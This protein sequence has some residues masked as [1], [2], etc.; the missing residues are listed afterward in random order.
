YW[1]FEAKTHTYWT[2]DSSRL[3][4]MSRGKWRPVSGE[5][6]SDYK[7][8]LVGA[9]GALHAS[10]TSQICPFDL[11]AA[12]DPQQVDLDN[13]T[14]EQFS[15]Q[16][17]YARPIARSGL[18]QFETQACAA[19]V[20]GSSRNVHVNVRVEALASEPILLPI[21]IMAYRYKDETY[22]FLVNGQ[23]GKSTGKAPTSLMKIAGVA[24]AI[25]AVIMLVLFLLGLGGVAGLGMNEIEG[26]PE[27][28]P[29]IALVASSIAGS[30]PGLQ[31]CNTQ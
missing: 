16:R 9:S 6:R 29:A 18:D 13:V 1:V 8:I 24:V 25:F 3:P 7:G 2:A 28:E 20:P 26:K 17:K 21:W 30:R 10:E 31:N 23:T 12:K 14:V 11:S 5:H 19:L 27:Y 4:A 22:R 15:V